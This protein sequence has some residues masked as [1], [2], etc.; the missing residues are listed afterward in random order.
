MGNVPDRVTCLKTK[1]YGYRLPKKEKS[2]NTL[3]Y[4]R[5]KG[6]QAKPDSLVLCEGTKLNMV[7]RGHDPSQEFLIFK[8][9]SFRL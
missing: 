5:L 7:T 3:A 9:R 6:R 4:G 2:R 1:E 8:T